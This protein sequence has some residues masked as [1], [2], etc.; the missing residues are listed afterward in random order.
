MWQHHEAQL[1]R[2][3]WWE[4]SWQGEKIC[5]L[6]LQCA[7][8]L[9]HLEYLKVIV[10][11]CIFSGLIRVGN[12]AV[13]HILRSCKPVKTLFYRVSWLVSVGHRS[14]VSLHCFS[15]YWVISVK[16]V[17]KCCV[18]ETVPMLGKDPGFGWPVY[19]TTLCSRNH[20]I[21]RGNHQPYC[22]TNSNTF[23]DQQ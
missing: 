8:L 12:Q 1:T 16:C 19:V 9:Q 10:F 17:D 18:M 22:F 6:K 11:L 3:L 14:V 13:H 7:Y 21:I 2:V 5:W 23:F 20:S 15:L 4:Y